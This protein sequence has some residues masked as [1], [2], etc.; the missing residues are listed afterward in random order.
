[1]RKYLLAITAL[2]LFATG[3]G[4]DNE[5]TVTPNQNSNANAFTAGIIAQGGMPK[6][7]DSISFNQ[8]KHYRTVGNFRCAYRI[9]T[10]VVVTRVNNN[11]LRLRVKNES[12][13]G[14]RNSTYCPYYHPT[15]RDLRYQSMTKN[16]FV[17]KTTQKINSA[18]NP[19]VYCAEKKEWCVNFRTLQ[20]TDTTKHGIPAILVEADFQHRNGD[21]LKRKVWVSKVSLLHNVFEIEMTNVRT[22]E[23]VDYKRLK[24]NRRD[25]RH[26]RR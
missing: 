4:K 25:R 15:M 13:G 16:E 7:K 18:L 14:R 17:Q 8:K 20:K 6:T 1:M 5:V 2:T 19:S 24:P 11:N 12:Q 22:G 9:E 23:I 3:C 21:L 10:D 26:P